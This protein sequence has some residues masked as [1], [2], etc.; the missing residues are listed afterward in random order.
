[1]ERAIKVMRQSIDEIREDGKSC[2][3]VGA[4]ILKEN[5]L[6]EQSC[7]GELRQG[8]HAE[9][10]LLD[11]KNRNQKLDNSILF[12]TLEPCAPGARNKPKLSCAERIVNA[13]IKKVYIG[14]EDK[15]PTVA[16][17]G[18]QFLKEHGVEVE[19][20]P[21]NLQ[22]QIIEA[23]K[24]FMAE[25]TARAKA[26]ETAT[27]TFSTLE[28]S[29]KHLSLKDFDPD[30]KRK[31]LDKIEEISGHALDDP[32]SHFLQTGILNKLKTNHTI[33]S[34]FGLLLFGKH[35]RNTLPQAGLL[36]KVRYPNGN[37]ENQDFDKA[38][39]LIPGLLEEWLHKVLA[40]T[41]D[42]SHMER[43]DSHDVPM[44]LIREAV[45]NALIHRDYDI[46]GAKC[47]L[48]IDE[49]YIHV[50]SPGKPIK[51]ITLE[52]IKAFNAP[53]LSRNPLL[54]FVFSQMDLA[55]EKGYGL[56]SLKRRSNELRLP[57]P[58]YQYQAPYLN[59][60]LFRNREAA[61]GSVEGSSFSSNEQAIWQLIQ[62]KG[63][64]KSSEI[65]TLLKLELRTTQRILSKLQ[66]KNLIHKVGKGPAT[67]YRPNL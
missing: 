63:E 64:M 31:Y 42:R 49:N 7:R 12:V 53:M 28:Q 32:T 1:M 66:K 65:S 67:S 40:L 6:V 23:N 44:E 41:S 55:E 18:I 24:E 51:P 14:I 62:N 20:F 5:G 47:Q 4:V 9:Y 3:K 13:R 39:V 25:A 61:M 17:K 45:V 38:M 35:P 33:P 10:S 19:M 50:K 37:E 36:A 11:R 34:G 52:Q 46:T 58:R 60:T 2:P 29:C 8:D 21:R 16:R 30:A 57:L 43:Q 54:H 15:D 48:E 26:A 56:T 22:E 59:L 27:S